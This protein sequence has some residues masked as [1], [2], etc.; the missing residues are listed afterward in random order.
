MHGFLVIGLG[1]RGDRERE[2]RRSK[3]ETRSVFD[4]LSLFGSISRLLSPKGG[5]R[6]ISFSE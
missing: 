6:R 1:T 5:E 3:G 2:V 4:S